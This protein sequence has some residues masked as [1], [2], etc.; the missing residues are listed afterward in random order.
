MALDPK[1]LLARALL[2]GLEEVAD[3]I[4]R[5][6][7]ELGELAQ[8]RGLVENPRRVRRFDSPQVASCVACGNST[9]RRSPRGLPVCDDC[10][11]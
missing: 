4:R 2:A 8:E 5:G 1:S 10:A 3:G 7:G 6:V 9:R 11:A